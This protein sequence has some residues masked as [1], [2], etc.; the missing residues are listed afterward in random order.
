LISV[1]LLLQD[2]AEAMGCR[3][4]EWNQRTESGVLFSKDAEANDANQPDC[5]S[6]DD[7]FDDGT[8]ERLPD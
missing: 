2:F 3:W 8:D 4:A 1:V 5:G 6:G 7:D